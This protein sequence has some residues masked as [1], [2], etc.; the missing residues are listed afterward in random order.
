MP[1]VCRY[2]NRLKSKAEI[3][4][5]VSFFPPCEADCVLSS[6]RANAMRIC[7]PP[8]NSL[9]FFSQSDLAKP[10]PS[11]TL[12]RDKQKMS[13]WQLDGRQ[14]KNVRHDGWRSSP[15]SLVQSI[16]VLNRPE[17]MTEITVLS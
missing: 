9:H 13:C 5:R 10:R 6:K 16:R 11:R 12:Q 4:T 8:E 1:R 14:D 3:H 17:Y 15:R 7:H 2:G